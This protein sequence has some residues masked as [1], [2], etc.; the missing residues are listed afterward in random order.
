MI[1]YISEENQTNKMKEMAEKHEWDLSI[2]QL[3]G[4]KLSDYISER[5]QIITNL[6]YLIID[7][8]QLVDTEI[9]LNETIETLKYMYDVQVIVLETELSDENGEK[10]NVIYR[11]HY[12]AL[13]S[14]DEHVWKNIE[15][16]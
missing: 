11:S 4:A 8:T 14:S 13:L 1:I 5:L 10:K 3:Q 12:I 9:E 6:S 2:D 16:I 15:Y 7:R